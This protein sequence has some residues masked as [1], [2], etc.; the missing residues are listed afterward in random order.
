[1]HKQIKIQFSLLILV[2]LG[3]PLQAD[4]LYLR[5]GKILEGVIR[6]HNLESIEFE[7][8]NGETHLIHKS[9]I[10]KV[11]FKK[12][13]KKKKEQELVQEYIP[14]IFEVV[15]DNRVYTI[16]VF[17]KN[18]PNF[19]QVKLVSEKAEKLQRYRNLSSESF[20]LIVDPEGMELG[21]YD[22]IVLDEQGR[23]LQKY[24][25][26]VQIVDP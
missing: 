22:L 23:E 10:Q 26:L 9:K 17:G 2:L 15:R 13:I 20:I 25:A 24:Q 5:D 4:I 14:I 6:K 21:I 1:M 12:F 3:R 19:I 8:E 11:R 7:N 16:P 18:F